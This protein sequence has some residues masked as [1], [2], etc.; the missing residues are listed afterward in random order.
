MRSYYCCYNQLFLT[1]YWYWCKVWDCKAWESWLWW[2]NIQ[3]Q[4]TSLLINICINF[5]EKLTCAWYIH[6]S[7][8]GNSHWAPAVWQLAPQWL[9]GQS[10][11]QDR[12]RTT[13]PLCLILSL[14]GMRLAQSQFL[15]LEGGRWVS[16]LEAGTG[17]PCDV[18]SKTSGAKVRLLGWDS[19][20]PAW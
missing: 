18:N 12:H 5:V 9:W 17:N 11:E 20:S 10:T 7:V 1:K 3:C 8:S 15:Q 19:A 14:S 13:F 2:E 4:N 6:L 16:L